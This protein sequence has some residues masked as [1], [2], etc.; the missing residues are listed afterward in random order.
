MGFCLNCWDMPGGFLSQL[1]GHAWWVSVSI[2]GTCLVE[3][4]FCLGNVSSFIN[5]LSFFPLKQTKQQQVTA[6]QHRLIMKQKCTTPA[7][8][9]LQNIGRETAKVS[10]IASSPNY[11]EIPGAFHLFSNTLLEQL[12]GG[13]GGGGG[14]RLLYLWWGLSPMGHFLSGGGGGCCYGCVFHL[15]LFMVL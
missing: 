3:K 11:I 1:L 5:I 12:V 4:V 13:G 10:H 6:A 8:S 14:G 15:R 7:A 2:V 9:V